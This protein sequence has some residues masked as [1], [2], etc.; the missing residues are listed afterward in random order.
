MKRPSRP[1]VRMRE[2]LRRCSGSRVKWRKLFIAGAMMTTA[3]VV[4]QMFSLPYP[5]K[6]WFLA[7]QV[8]VSSLDEHL[9]ATMALSSEPVVKSN[10]EHSQALVPGALSS[11]NLVDSPTEL[12]LSPPVVP[13]RST[14]WQRKK[15]VARRRKNNRVKKISPPPPPPPPRRVIPYRLQV[16]SLFNGSIICRKMLYKLAA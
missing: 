1:S 12:N 9:N 4:L 8:T 7:T 15:S 6:A 13:E 14:P 3:G 16:N 11:V 2:C 10:V 5:L